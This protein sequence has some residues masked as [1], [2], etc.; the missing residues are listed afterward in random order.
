MSW[1]LAITLALI[2]VRNIQDVNKYNEADVWANM[3]LKKPKL[4]SNQK[5]RKTSYKPPIRFK[6]GEFVHISL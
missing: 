1:P 6:I 4:K 5:T 2:G 3:Y